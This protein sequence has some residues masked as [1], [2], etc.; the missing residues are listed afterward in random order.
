MIDNSGHHDDMVG[1]TPDDISVG[2]D[3]MNTVGYNKQTV[4]EEVCGR[5]RD[6]CDKEM[7]HS[8]DDDNKGDDDD[9]TMSGDGDDDTRLGDDV[10][11]VERKMCHTQL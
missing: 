3:G 6:M 8:M 10:V 2:G 4:S 7:M 5:Q 9:I 11:S 1:N